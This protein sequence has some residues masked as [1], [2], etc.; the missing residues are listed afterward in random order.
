MAFTFATISMDWNV[1]KIRFRHPDTDKV[2]EMTTTEID[3]DTDLRDAL[4]TKC[5]TASP[6]A[7][8][9]KD[10][11]TLSSGVVQASGGGDYAGV[12]DPGYDTTT[13]YQGLTKAGA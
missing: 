13:I 4:L 7:S 9:H 5:L 12:G 10:N 8:T 2:V 11:Y 3:A 6:S 1:S